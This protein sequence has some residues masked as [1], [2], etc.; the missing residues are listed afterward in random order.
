MVSPWDDE[1][2]YSNTISDQ[3]FGDSN[4]LVQFITP[5]PVLPPPQPAVQPSW[6]GEAAQNA[7]HRFYDI[8]R[9]VLHGDGPN[10]APALR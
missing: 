2:E 6:V 10:S 5:T 4:Q 9:A 7:T 8:L 1:E 3:A